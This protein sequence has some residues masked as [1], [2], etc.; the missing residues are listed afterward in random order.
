MFLAHTNDLK[1][2]KFIP[3]AQ[4]KN[5]EVL[6]NN[7][8]FKL[9]SNVCPHQG[10][11]ISR[12]FG[13]SNIRV[14][15]YHSWSF[16]LNGKPVASGRTVKHC[17]NSE[18]LA[19]RPVFEFLNLLFDRNITVPELDWLDL[20]YMHLVEQ[21]VD[22]VAASQ[23]Q[24]MDLFL[25]VDHIETVHAG[26]YDQIGISNINDVTWSFYNWG[27]LQIVNTD[28]ENKAAWLAVYPGTMIEWQKGALFVTVAEYIN[29]RY[30]K[31]HVFK[32]KDSRHEDIW[33]LNERVWETAWAQDKEQ[34]SLLTEFTSKNLEES[35]KHFRNWL[36]Y[37]STSIE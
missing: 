15:P 20:G 28:G 19:N 7:N 36:I 4:L 11:I 24:I 16:D 2:K 37:D 32:Y 27:N 12:T 26:V 22:E 3:L 1:D 21:R 10:S 6:V 14:C 25:D 29:D 18:Y 34:A 17:Q 9:V 5:L 23:Y 8:G 30:S 33:N 35:K 31:V 13:T